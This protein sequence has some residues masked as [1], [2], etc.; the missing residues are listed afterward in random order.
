[1]KSFFEENFEYQNEVNQDILQQLLALNE[2]IPIKVLDLLS[3]SMNAHKLWNYRILVK[4]EKVD[5]V[6]HSLDQLLLLD[7]H[8]FNDTLLV[9]MNKDLSEKISYHS[10]SG[11]AYSN[12]IQ[13][14][15]TQVSLHFQYHRGQI[16]SELL[17]HNIKLKPTDY[18]YF[19]RKEN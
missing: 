10:M 9:L 6:T 4:T 7:I 12:T 15:L 1:M 5:F 17:K 11:K 18:I 16:I 19:S 13:E 14:I 8:N 3:H 2:E